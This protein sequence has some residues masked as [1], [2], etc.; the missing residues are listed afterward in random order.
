M[1]IVSRLRAG[2]RRR[3]LSS[4]PRSAIWTPAWPSKPPDF[5][6]WVQPDVAA[7]VVAFLVSEEAGTL[8]GAWLPVFGSI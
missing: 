3:S 1:V 4:R 5:T 2:T 7:A 6:R 8:R